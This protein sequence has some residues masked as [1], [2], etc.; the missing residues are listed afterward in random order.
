MPCPAAGRGRV[1]KALKRER[2]VCERRS[3]V[4]SCSTIATAV[5][6]FFHCHK[7]RSTACACRPFRYRGSVEQLR[8]ALFHVGIDVAERDGTQ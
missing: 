4:A 8:G 7:F 2:R 6:I 5:C 1:E 3:N